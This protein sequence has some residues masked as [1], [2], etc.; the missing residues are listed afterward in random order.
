[1][2]LWD[3]FLLQQ[4][5]LPPVPLGF[6]LLCLGTGEWMKWPPKT[7][8][9]LQKPSSLPPQAPTPRWA[10]VPGMWIW[11]REGS[12][13]IDKLWPSVEN[14]VSLEYSTICSILLKSPLHSPAERLRKG[15]AISATCWLGKS[16]P[17]IHLFPFYEIWMVITLH[18]LW[19]EN[20]VNERCTMLGTCN[21]LIV[22]V[23][24]VKY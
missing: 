15:S 1:M 5:R 14:E 22:C 10:G 9:A 16:L 23:L 6:I 11:E 12:K 17:L 21:T 8:L 3:L 2:N 24:C 20:S 4:E 19:I 13:G 18:D 7:F